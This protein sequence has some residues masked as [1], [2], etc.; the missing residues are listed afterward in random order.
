MATSSSANELVMYDYTGF[1][2]VMST[3][4]EGRI[5]TID[6]SHDERTIAVGGV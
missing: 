4:E 6:F 1:N 2:V 5:N 3:R